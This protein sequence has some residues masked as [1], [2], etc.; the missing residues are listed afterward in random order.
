LIKTAVKTAEM[1]KYVDNV[2]H[3]LK[4]TYANEIGS[5]CKEMGVDAREVMS[6]FC[7]DQKLNLSP[8]YLKP[9]FAYGGSCLPKDLRALTR[10]AHARDVEVPLL[11]SISAS[12]EHQIKTALQLVMSK[13]KRKIG[14]LGFAFKG[15]TDDLRESPV[16][17]LVEGLLGKGYDIKLYDAYVSVAR[18]VGANRKYIEQHIPHLSRLMVESTTDIIAH[19]ETIII[20]N[21][22]EE[23][24]RVL[25]TL[26]PDQCVVDLR[27]VSDAVTTPAQYE[28]VCA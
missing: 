15:G 8:A 6:I 9:G 14:V 28:R 16:V 4:V 2:F 19:A 21:Q 23:I 11:N 27:P 24:A 20:G 12:N 10:L 7:H 5:I 1:V 3:A 17:T 25:P 13:G 22:S 18:L 26:R